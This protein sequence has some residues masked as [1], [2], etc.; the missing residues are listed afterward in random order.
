MRG[1]N[2]LS[3]HLP[4]KIP[5]WSGCT[6]SSQ[7]KS[8]EGT[9][10]AE[11]ISGE[12]TGGAGGDPAGAPP[13]ASPGSPGS[14]PVRRDMWRRD[15]GLNARTLLGL[16]NKEFTRRNVR[17]HVGHELVCGAFFD[18][19]VVVGSRPGLLRELCRRPARR[20]KDQ[21]RKSGWTAVQRRVLVIWS[22]KTETG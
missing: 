19:V 3:G 12:T 5:S 6:K 14:R 16:L 10:S 17:L 15:L 4:S 2:K 8:G 9:P 20:R 18:V 13:T 11:G 1:K 21:C 7:L 22:W